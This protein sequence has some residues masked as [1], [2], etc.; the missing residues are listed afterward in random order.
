M[1]H[2]WC[3]DHRVEADLVDLPENDPGPLTRALGGSLPG[4]A[5]SVKAIVHPARRSPRAMI[6]RRC[7]LLSAIC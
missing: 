1:Q 4:M 6:L 2:I 3:D 5:G 7:V